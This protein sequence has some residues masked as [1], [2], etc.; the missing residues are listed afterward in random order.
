MKMQIACKNKLGNHISSYSE[1]GM[2]VFGPA[3][4]AFIDFCI[5]V[6]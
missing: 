5:T 2:A 3:G 1:L 6:S 4:K